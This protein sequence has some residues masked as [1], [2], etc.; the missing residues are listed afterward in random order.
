MKLKLILL[1][2]L[3]G[4]GLPGKAQEFG[5]QF[6]DWVLKEAA[7]NSRDLARADYQSR[8]GH[9]MTK[10]D[11]KLLHEVQLAD[12][13]L[14][15]VYD[16]IQR[17]E[18][19]L[20]GLDSLLATLE[21]AKSARLEY[22]NL[23]EAENHLYTASLLKTNLDSLGTPVY[24]MEQGLYHVGRETLM[25]SYTSVGESFADNFQQKY[26]YDYTVTLGGTVDSDGNLTG[27]SGT[28]TRDNEMSYTA[29]GTGVGGGL[30]A[31][32]GS[33]TP[34]GP[35]GGAI[36][37][38]VAGGL[39]GGTA[40]FLVGKNKA[41]KKREADEKKFKKQMVFLQEGIAALP[42]QLAPV[43]TLLK[44]YQQIA[45]R[46]AGLNSAAYLHLDTT[47]RLQQQR[48]REIFAYNVR[49]Q[50]LSQ[51]QLTSGKIALIEQR[52]KTLEGLRNFYSNLA[53]VDF[54]KDCDQMYTALSAEKDWLRLAAA[55]RFDWLQ[56][57]EAYEDNLR[58]ALLIIR[59]FLADETYLPY[60]TYLGKRKA[61]LEE[62]A[63]ELPQQPLIAPEAKNSGGLKLAM[64]PA[65]GTRL[66]L[67]LPQGITKPGY[68]DPPAKLGVCFGSG[69]YALCSGITTDTYGTR[70][71]NNGQSPVTDILGSAHDGGLQAYNAIA[72]RQIG[73]ARADIQRRIVNLR[74]DDENFQAVLPSAI[75]AYR[76]ESGRLAA[77]ATDLGVRSA[78]GISRFGAQY[79][80]IMPELQRQLD[81]FMNQPV[82]TGLTDLQKNLRLNQRLG[83]QVPADALPTAVFRIAGREMGTTARQGRLPV[84][85][86]WDREKGKQLA[87]LQAIAGRVG[88]A[89]A[90]DPVFPD[91][92]AFDAFKTRLGLIDGL[93]E[94]VDASGVYSF[95]DQ[96]RISAHFLGE[97]V[98]M[99]YAATGQ[100]PGRELTPANYPFLDAEQRES[101]QQLTESFKTCDP[102]LDDCDEAYGRA[103]YTIAG[104][105][106]VI[107]LQN[108]EGDALSALNLQALAS[109]SSEWQPLGPA[110]ST[111]ALTRATL[112]AMTGNAVLAVRPDGLGVK[113]GVILPA[114]P[115]E[116]TTGNWK[117]HQVPQMLY[118]DPDKRAASFAAGPMSDAFDDPA[119]VLLYTRPKP[120][121]F[122][123][124]GIA[125]QDK[126]VRPF[127]YSDPA[128]GLQATVPAL[129]LTI[130]APSAAGEES[131]EQAVPVA[132][133]YVGRI[134]KQYGANS[135]QVFEALYARREEC[136]GGYPADPAG[137]TT[138]EGGKLSDLRKQALVFEDKTG[139][140]NSPG[141][142]YFCQ[143]GRCL[144]Q[145]CLAE[146]S[147]ADPAERMKIL[148]Y[149][150]E[151]MGALVKYSQDGLN[152]ATSLLPFVNDARDLYELT[153]GMDMI[154]GEELKL[155]ERA[156]SGAG[157][158]IGSGAFFRN[159]ATSPAI[160]KQAVDLA[161]KGIPGVDM[162]KSGSLKYHF[163]SKEGIIYHRWDPSIPDVSRRDR[164]TKIMEDHA[165][166]A[167]NKTFFT[168][169]APSEIPALIDEAWA[170]AKAKK[171]QPF[172]DGIEK[173]SMYIVDM[174]RPVGKNERRFI[175]IV[176]DDT[177]APGFIKTSY[178]S[179]GKRPLP[180][181]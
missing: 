18:Q 4:F 92:N 66:H 97:A 41:K 150:D 48:F 73:T 179:H 94:R 84:A 82:R 171:L 65:G 60:F 45:A 39:V 153:T 141:R 117:G 52:F 7:A 6:R 136:F 152:I 58:F 158:L 79:A 118:L 143:T 80:A 103:I 108:E 159:I 114:L 3:I 50:Q 154:T 166:G 23:L 72:T 109:G 112:M 51:Q 76:Q 105:R 67:V 101:L 138:A 24:F 38:S 11:E 119:G 46:A 5:E 53:S 160:A 77:S 146:L 91:R 135:S 120:L 20:T 83:A 145:N 2:V 32:F 123:N 68:Q 113:A 147:T 178:P 9:A 137:L 8:V 169:N 161:G 131:P 21:R 168:V 89:G 134:S 10:I 174:G 28:V 31:F 85:L 71:N 98:K 1:A 180:K 116:S 55:G 107:N 13:I 47:L 155:W 127:A 70:F 42:G 95:E 64:K 125:V 175:D 177:K 59:Q 106:S 25:E 81:Q 139:L 75:A 90:G 121:D 157:L 74:Q 148:V 173:T 34:V 33:G 142:F 164:L 110:S 165:P 15:A 35:I 151:L 12:S 54:T 156:V 63:G 87:A 36:I 124:P 93:L 129:R 49:R 69:G 130:K 44:Y 128:N 170:I 172:T 14:N 104:D 126:G 144:Y 56:R 140:L 115:V 163:I 133:D 27:A 19:S 30:G 61:Q 62:M 96:A 100:L 122:G 40:D 102:D 167:K 26:R 111:G 78:A 29:I 162:I 17:N 181:P 37:G 88:P 176:F 16:R 149:Y 22:Y 57:R 43:D 132:G 86:A 99:R